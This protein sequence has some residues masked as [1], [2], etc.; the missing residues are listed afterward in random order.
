MRRA[1]TRGIRVGCG[2]PRASVVSYG[3]EAARSREVT[4]R[5]ALHGP[6][7]RRS[8][9]VVVGPMPR[10]QLDHA[11]G[12]QRRSGGLPAGYRPVTRLLSARSLDAFSICPRFCAP[13]I[14]WV[15][16]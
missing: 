10:R 11:A 5:A 1:G 12:C 6:I 3:G 15:A 4:G 14:E 2:E 13:V 7:V 8:L 16:R 9:Y